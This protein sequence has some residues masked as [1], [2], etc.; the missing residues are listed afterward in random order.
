MF[1]PFKKYIQLENRLENKKM[2]HDPSPVSLRCG[3][4]RRWWTVPP[5]QTDHRQTGWAHHCWG[6]RY[7]EDAPSTPPPGLGWRQ[8]NRNRGGEMVIRMEEEEVKDWWGP[9]SYLRG[10]GCLTPDPKILQFKPQCMQSIPP[11]ILRQDTQTV[12]LQCFWRIKTIH[13][14]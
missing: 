4:H 11:A 2:I 8:L 1:Y 3:R 6:P 13:V 10:L 9:G 14:W 12:P 5:R 7:E